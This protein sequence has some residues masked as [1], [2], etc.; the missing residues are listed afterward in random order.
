MPRE[1]AQ[2]HNPAEKFVAVK[3][4]N[5]TDCTVVV[6]NGEILLPLVER[7]TPREAEGLAHILNELWRVESR[8]KNGRHAPCTVLWGRSYLPFV[9]GP[10]GHPV[11]L[12]T[13]PPRDAA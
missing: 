2:R 5:T 8:R 10:Y 7:L 12:S 1:N 4:V 9:V 6:K 13:A 11:S 3:E